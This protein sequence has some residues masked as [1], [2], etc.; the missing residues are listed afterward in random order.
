MCFDA[1]IYIIDDHSRV[2]LSLIPGRNGSDYINA[3]Y[4]NVSASRHI[5]ILIKQVVL[6]K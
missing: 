4:I 5:L 3:N 6:L 1:F 2:P